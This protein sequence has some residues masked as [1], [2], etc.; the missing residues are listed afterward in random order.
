MMLKKIILSFLLLQCSCQKQ[1]TV[2]NNLGVPITI[3]QAKQALAKGVNLSN[4]FNDYSNPA[5]YG[6]HFSSTDMQRIKAAGFTYIRLPIASTI[7]FNES[8]PSELKPS[9]LGFIDQAIQSAIQVGL[10]VVLDP[11][12]NSNDDFEKKLATV[13]GFVD[14]VSIYWQAVAKYFSKYNPDQLF[15]EIYNEPHVGT[16]GFANGVSKSWWW[17]M[18]GRFIHA[19]RQVTINHYLIAGA[20]GW[21]NRN[22]LISNIPYKEENVIYNFHFYD[23]F[24]FTH[25]GASWAGW[26]PAIEAAGVPYPSS[27]NA[28]DSL[29]KATPHQELKDALTWYGS[30]RYNLDTLV[31]WVKPVANWAKKYNV[32]VTC[33]E[34]GSYKPYSPRKSR[35]NWINDMRKALETNQVVWAIW[36]YDE[37]FGWINYTNNNRSQPTIDREILTALGL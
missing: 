36:E 18:Q 12:H 13:S 17:P 31:S 2:S 5:E 30:Q 22:E 33:N 24:L 4:W 25:Q 8:S 3:E 32:M 28:V 29:I 27:P 7:L 21:N 35:L 10:A 23:P 6:N 37:G 26:P 16:S 9:P 15:F 11:I 19:I 1:V 14:K 34:F 20:E